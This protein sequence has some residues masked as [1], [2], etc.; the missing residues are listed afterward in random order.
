[1]SLAEL[2]PGFGDAVH[3]AQGCFRVL[4]DAMSHPG[5]V[6]P[7]PAAT[8]AALQPPP[9]LGIGLAALL[10]TVLDGETRVALLG[11][12]DSEA[13]RH[14]LRFHT[15]VACSG[16]ASG[17]S[18]AAVHA[19][20]VR[21]GLW[22][23][24]PRGTDTEPQLGATLLVQVPMLAEVAGWESLALRGP[25]IADVQRLHV[26]GLPRSFWAERI[27]LERDRPRGIELVLVAGDR[28][29]AIPRSTRVGWMD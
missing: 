21:A 19:D 3:D 15:G 6:L 14:W 22:S 28:I 23:Q 20:E 16:D 25:G 12:C 29:A 10:L 7:L 26:D 2:T 11:R 24:L 4:L 1:M 9:G 8:L 13:A 18:F 5:R 17:T 27:A